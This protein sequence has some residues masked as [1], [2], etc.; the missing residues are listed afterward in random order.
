MANSANVTLGMIEITINSKSKSIITRLYKAL[1]RPQLEYCVQVW[2]PYLKK[3]IEKIEKVQRRATRMISECS[4]LSYED[5]LNI[6]G[7]PTLEARRNRG[8]LIEVF[9][10]LKGFSKVDYKHYFQLVNSSKTRGNKYKL[11]KS[12]SRLDIRKHFFSQRVVNEWNKLPDSVI[13]AESVNSFKNKYDSYV[14]LQRNNK[15]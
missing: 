9:K 8:D 11:V 10:I 7:L 3:D 2:R 1:V 5:R 13:E 14:S 4:K 12:R 15:L 6:T